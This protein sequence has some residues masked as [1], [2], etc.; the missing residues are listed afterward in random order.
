M[1][2]LCKKV[3]SEGNRFVQFF[4]LSPLEDLFRVRHVQILLMTWRGNDADR[5]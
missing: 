5:K 1:R 2:V 3:T 4:L